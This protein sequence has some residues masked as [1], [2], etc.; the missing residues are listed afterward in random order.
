MS[1]R[2]EGTVA[3]VTGG[4]AGYGKGIA[5]KLTAEGAKVIIM[6]LNQQAGQQTAAELKSMFIHTDVTN[7]SDWETALRAAINSFGRLDIV[8]NN[9]G[10]SHAQKPTDTTTVADFDQCINVNLKSLFMSTTVVLP[11]LL[12]RKSPAVFIT[13]ASTGGI[14]PRPGLTW[15]AASKAAVNTASNAMAIEYAAKGIRFNTVCP[16]VGLTNMYVFRWSS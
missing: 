14:R 8:V 6:D 10:V 15:Y 3:I 5:L 16:V 11:Y 2:L 7:R 13:I 4:A 1:K 9:A 12:E